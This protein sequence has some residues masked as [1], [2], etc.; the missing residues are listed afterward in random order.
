VTDAGGK[1]K[2][3]AEEKKEREERGRT[4]TKLDQRPLSFSTSTSSSFSKLHTLFL[5]RIRKERPPFVFETHFVFFCTVLVFLKRK[6]TKKVGRK[7]FLC[8]QFF[9]RIFPLLSLSLFQGVEGR[10]FCSLNFPPLDSLSHDL[11]T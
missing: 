8:R 9:S 7:A 4:T 6:R 3:I 2:K 10:S 1:G 11:K 5:S